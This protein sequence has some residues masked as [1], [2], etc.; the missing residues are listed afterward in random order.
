MN[1]AVNA[2]FCK[3]NEEGAE[4]FCHTCHNHYCRKCQ[5]EHATNLDTKHHSN[6]LYR[7]ISSHVP[8]KKETC[9]IHLEC[10]YQKFCESCNIPI[11]DL[12]KG[13]RKHKK[14]K[15]L[16]AY[17]SKHKQLKEQIFKIRC[18]T[19]YQFQIILTELK[20]DIKHCLKEKK[21]LMSAMIVM[22]RKIKSYMDKALGHSRYLKDVHS[23]SSQL[24]RIKKHINKIQY[25]EQIQ[26]TL[27]RRPVKF[28]KFIKTLRPPSMEDTPS[29]AL[30][31]MLSMT[32]D[33]NVKD[34]I[35]PL[36]KIKMIKRDKRCLK[37]SKLLKVI[38]PVN[39]IDSYVIKDVDRCHHISHVTLD[40]V[41]VNDGNSLILADTTT[42]VT[43]KRLPILRYGS[44]LG[45]H[46]VNSEREL[47][48]IENSSAVKKYCNDMSTKT[49]FKMKK[50]R[51]SDWLPVCLYCSPSTGDLLI[52][53]M[54]YDTNKSK[55]AR[56]NKQG[57]QTQTIQNDKNGQAL[58]HFPRYITENNNG[59]VV[60]SDSIDKS[61]GAV[62][63]TDRDG[64]H[65]FSYTGNQS[66]SK[67]SPL[68]ICT[69]AFSNI[70]VCDWKTQLVHVIEESGKFYSTWGPL[71]LD[72]SGRKLTTI[73]YSL[74]Y[75]VNTHLLWVGSG[76]G[77]VV[78]AFRYI[79]RHSHLTGMF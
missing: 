14:L 59:D 34:L 65:R 29:L 33:I 4:Y 61:Y 43:L 12:C 42:G 75:D 10:T 53:K 76:H 28:L 52:G 11:C 56:Y 60:V 24:E 50:R 40:R 49:V 36:T 64:M 32:P 5:Q 27:I 20:D 45:L 71:V 69:D 55:V 13:H 18:D 66:G 21:E 26:E 47:I 79:H 35:K 74:S 62:V 46:S 17:E 22:S 63:V 73:P 67:L 57:K 23:C 51:Y 54:R 15:L 19:I 58:Y 30:H 31:S 72:K 37:N 1:S 68:G 41:W 6:N 8:N 77:N 25:Y 78:S 39:V 3:C 44:C 9:S 7:N 16:K 48:Y 38:L 70:L 2:K